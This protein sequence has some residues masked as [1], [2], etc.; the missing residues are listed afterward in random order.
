M[1]TKVG[2]CCMGAFFLIQIPTDFLGV[3]GKAL[4]F[5]KESDGGPCSHLMREMGQRGDGEDVRI[6]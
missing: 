3:D 6:A 2:L 4:P 1:S 5:V